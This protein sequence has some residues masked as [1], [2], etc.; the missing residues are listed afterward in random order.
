MLKERLTR[1]SSKK[2]RKTYLVKMKM[3]F[4]HSVWLLL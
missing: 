1:N 2:S 4:S 3:L